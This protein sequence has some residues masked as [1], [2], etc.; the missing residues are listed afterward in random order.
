MHI[1]VKTPT[2]RTITLDVEINDTIDSIKAKIH[3][4]ESLSPD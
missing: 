1:F 2:G 4:K 3:E